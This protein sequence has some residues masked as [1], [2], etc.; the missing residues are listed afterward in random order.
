M[1]NKEA[2]KMK[3]NTKLGKIICVVIAL[4]LLA[5]IIMLF[6]V[7]FNKHITYRKGTK[8]EAKINNG[9]EKADI[10]AMAK[11][12][13]P[14]RE[15]EVQDIEKLNQVFAVKLENYTEEELNDFKAKIVEKYELKKDEVTLE[16]V[17]VPAARVQSLVKPYVF[18]MGL[19][20]VL[21]AVY[22]AVRNAKNKNAG[23]KVVQLLVTLLA[24]L[25]LYFSIIMITR[26]PFSPETMPL[27][28]TVYVAALLGSIMHMN[29]GNK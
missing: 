15:I 13:F 14:N 2:M 25:G 8:I 4:I 26:I 18:S 7:G 21:S 12:A 24:A 10:E 11:E 9:Y 22:V 19:V 20:T 23:K 5:G 17:P 29:R 28:L 6:T 1:V 16:E 27:A 3:M